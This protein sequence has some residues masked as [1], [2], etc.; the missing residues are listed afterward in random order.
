MAEQGGSQEKTEEASEHKLRQSRQ[1]GQVPRSKD[2]AGTVALLCTL[3]VLKAC[4]GRFFDGLADSF[5]FAYLDLHRS[6]V[7][8]DDLAL[9][10]GQHI[11]LMVQLLL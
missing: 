8:L 3:L 1:K 4:V 7:G 6:E 10:L 9:I 2:L 5:R 11:W